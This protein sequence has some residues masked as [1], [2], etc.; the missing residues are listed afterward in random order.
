MERFGYPDFLLATAD[1]LIDGQY[2]D[3]AQLRPIFDALID[4]AAGLGPGTIQARQ[5]YVSLVSPRRTFARVPATTKNPG[6]LG[7]RV[8][9]RKPK[10]RLP[11]LKNQKTMQGSI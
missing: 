10:G 3:R 6:D 2:A 11:P 5:T 4:A 1:E 8:E 7:L 9:G